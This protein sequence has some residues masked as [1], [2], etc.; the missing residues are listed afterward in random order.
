M[1]ENK[2]EMTDDIEYFLNKAKVAI[3]DAIL[4]KDPMLCLSQIRQAEIS[5]RSHVVYLQ[6]KKEQES[7][8]K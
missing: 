4:N 5:I 7:W 1:E 6:P 3:E 2:I 8:I